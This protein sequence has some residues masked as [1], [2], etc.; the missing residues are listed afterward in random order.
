MP[1]AKTWHRMEWSYQTEEKEL[2]CHCGLWNMGGMGNWANSDIRPNIPGFPE[3]VQ[4]RG[5]GPGVREH[6]ACLLRKAFMGI[7]GYPKLSEGDFDR[8]M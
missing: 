4:A 6:H 1:V 5:R 2:K 3:M 8:E 7:L